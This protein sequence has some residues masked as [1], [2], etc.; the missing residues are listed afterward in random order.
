MKTFLTD[1]DGVVLNWLDSFYDYLETY[2]GVVATTR[3]PDDFYAVGATVGLSEDEIFKHVTVFNDT[4]PDFCDLKPYPHALKNIQMLKDRGHKFVAITSAS[5]AIKRRIARRD[6]LDRYFPG[7]FSDVHCLAL[8]EDKSEYLEAYPNSFWVE[9][10]LSN[11]A[12]GVDAGHT[13]FL[14]SHPYNRG[15]VP[16]GYKKHITRV[17]GWGHIA[18]TIGAK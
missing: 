1:I 2:H 13:T 7:V 11:A 9:D 14:I 3:K 12:K 18:K 16:A 17:R 4:C 6:N 5:A 8:R 15:K 10:L